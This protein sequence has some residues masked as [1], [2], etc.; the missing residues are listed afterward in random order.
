MRKAFKIE[1]NIE[2]PLR[3][4]PKYPFGQMKVGDSFAV[5]GATHSIRVAASMYGIRHNLQFSVHIKGTTA[6]IW[7]TK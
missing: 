4:R 3:Y 7:R 5:R 2:P 1:S 6:R